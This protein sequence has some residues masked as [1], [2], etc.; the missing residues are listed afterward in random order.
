MD[1]LLS[2]K[3]VRR[4]SNS[5]IFR[6]FFVVIFS[7]IAIA[8]MIIAFT[9]TYFNLNMAFL[10][11]LFL[12]FA[13]AALTPFFFMHDIT[14]YRN[15]FEISSTFTKTPK[16]IA[17]DDITKWREAV[18]KEKSGDD[19]KGL[20]IY[21][22]LTNYLILSTEFKNYEEIKIGLTSGK[23]N[24]PGARRNFKLWFGS[25]SWMIVFILLFIGLFLLPEMSDIPD[26]KLIEVKVLLTRRPAHVKNYLKFYISNYPDFTLDLNIGSV[27]PEKLNEFNMDLSDPDS[28]EIILPKRVY[29]SKMVQEIPM[30]FSEKHIYYHDIQ[31][32]GVRHKDLLI[33][34]DGR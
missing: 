31:I 2:I 5:L 24:V 23:M 14:I 34:L 6:K 27:T 10:A 20:V 4:N 21:T 7:F 26:G 1:E 22:A 3:S 32:F 30:T 11:L 12:L 33:G 29:L 19:W 8:V 17:L 25:L 13:L 16:S 28:I 9:D 15:H 18:F